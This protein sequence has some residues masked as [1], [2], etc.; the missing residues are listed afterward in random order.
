MHAC[1]AAL[2]Q[3]LHGA[4]GTGNLSQLQFCAIVLGEVA[5]RLWWWLWWDY[6]HDSSISCNTGHVMDI[7]RP[8]VPAALVSTSSEKR[9][10]HLLRQGCWR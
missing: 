3:S 9:L 1:N 4:A 6:S 7:W 2:D 8:F 10:F 5:I